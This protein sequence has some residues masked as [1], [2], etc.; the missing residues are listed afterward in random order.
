V[1]F[2]RATRY[3]PTVSGTRR[4]RAPTSLL[5]DGMMQLL[6]PADEPVFLHAEGLILR[7]WT[8]EDVPDMVELFDSD[9]MNR[10]AP[11]PSPF[12]R[13]EA[14]RYVAA[15]HRQRVVDGTLQLAITLDGDAPLGEVLVFPGGSN[16]SV[17][18]AYAVGAAHQG[19]GL[20]RHA[21]EAVLA[22][23]AK[24]NSGVV[25]LVIA[26]DN[27]SSERV[28]LATG[29]RMTGVSPTQRRRKGF[30]LIMARWE[31]RLK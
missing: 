2:P 4:C 3:G 11:L 14:A 5:L 21:V 13:D 27:V 8:Y 22:L 28:A 9:E 16:G 18:L 31:R 25:E 1:P 26:T 6:W 12:D 15:A 7:E 29:F 17:E 23:A 20:G 24:S 30:V 10:W 19:R